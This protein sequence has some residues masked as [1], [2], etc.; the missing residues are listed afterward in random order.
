MEG[1]LFSVKF[2]GFDVYL[3]GQNSLSSV[4]IVW[5]KFTEVGAQFKAVL[6]GHKRFTFLIFPRFSDRGS[7][8]RIQFYKG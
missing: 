1:V 3:N 7:G 6:G 4:L 8:S 2:C 5:H